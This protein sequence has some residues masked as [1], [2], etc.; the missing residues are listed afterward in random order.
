[1]KMEKAFYYIVLSA[2]AIAT[3]FVVVCGVVSCS[4]KN[5][6]SGYTVVEST[7]GATKSEQDSSG[8]GENEASKEL[9]ETKE[10]EKSTEKVTEKET[11]PENA[12]EE[13]TT[14]PET[15]TETE[16]EETSET[17]EETTE[18]T[19]TS[20]DPSTPAGTPLSEHGALHVDGTKLT[21]EKG[22]PFVLRGV[23]THGL[24][25]FPDYVNQNAFVQMRDEWGINAVR[26]AMYTD[27]Y[28]GYC[29]G[30]NQNDLKKLVKKGVDYASQAGIYVIV[31]WHTLNGDG[32]NPNAHTDDSIAF[33]TE[34]AQYCKDKKNV[35]YEICN[36]PNSGTSWQSIKEYAGKVIP[37]IRG[38][39]PDAIIIV[40][41]PTWSQDVDQ[42][43]AS[44]ITGY[45]NIMYALHFYAAT[46]T[47][48]LRQRMVNAINAG[49]P[50]FVS[51]YGIC[52]ASGNGGINEKEANAWVKTMDDHGVSSMIWNLSNKDETSAL[53]SASCGKKS[54]Y[55]YDDL[56]TSGKW[57]Y[58]MMKEHGLAG[59]GSEEPKIDPSQTEKKP[60]K[61]QNT[62]A[63]A[64]K[65]TE[66]PGK[67]GTVSGENGGC[68][69]EAKV[70]SSWSSDGTDKTDSYV[71]EIT[72]TNT[73]AADLSGW[74]V[75]MTFTE[76]VTFPQDGW[77]N[78]ASV[79][80]NVV[81]VKV[82][83]P[84]AYNAVIPAHNT[85][86]GGGIVVKTNGQLSSVSVSCGA[87]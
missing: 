30:G 25:W 76:T 56:S 63:P 80:N 8:S 17:P 65:E 2:L 55:T 57:F 85:A 44:P 13:Q 7:T 32:K 23:S 60:E 68:K 52:D 47:D 79:N 15:E 24:A 50:V 86:E 4:K 11:E 46:H 49:L 16:T 45:N 53:I 72:L 18:Q 51:E 81:T 12:T 21:D 10:S 5:D 69:V 27:E 78:K 70:Q 35:I 29:T 39:D 62:P 42:A 71:Y 19:G 36:E 33:F 64:P 67:P 3:L 14:E 77:S 1:M 75:V 26:L 48:W 66:A 31:D 74:T 37:V 20:V 82:N 73:T 9:S 38:I 54:G 58:N 83:D 41:T 87:N 22:N 43:A 84:N 28:A 61:P 59:T 6:Q 40:G 34:M